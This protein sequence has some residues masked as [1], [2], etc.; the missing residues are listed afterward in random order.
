MGKKRLFGLMGFVAL[1][2]ACKSDGGG[3]SNTPSDGGTAS[4]T[5]VATSGEG[6]PA[7]WTLDDGGTALTV[8]VTRVDESGEADGGFTMR[9]AC[10][11]KNATFDYRNCAVTSVSPT[12]GIGQGPQAGGEFFLLEISGVAL[13]AHPKESTVETGGRN[14]HDLHVGLIRGECGDFSGSYN[15]IH[16]GPPGKL[17]GVFSRVN[18]VGSADGG[19]STI[20]HWDYGFVVNGA[21]STNR[22]DD[23]IAA[24]LVT[25]REVQHPVT[26]PSSSCS[27]GTVTMSF[28]GQGFDGGI[29]KVR[30]NMTSAGAI[31]LDKPRGR[32]GLIG[33]KS[34]AL[35]TLG[36]LQ[37][38]TYV[39]LNYKDDEGAQ[40]SNVSIDGDGGLRVNAATNTTLP[41]G[42]VWIGRFVPISDGTVQ[43]TFSGTDF[44]DLFNPVSGQAT[45]AGMIYAFGIPGPDGGRNQATT[46]SQLAGFFA[47]VHADGRLGDGRV[48]DDGGVGNGRFIL[49]LA[50]KKD[51]NI[52]LVG[53][54]VSVNND[55]SGLSDGGYTRC[56]AA[57]GVGP[58]NNRQ[59]Y[60]IDSPFIGYSK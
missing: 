37:G 7:V 14:R 47:T 23:P 54:H 31:L 16:V 9:A 44:V 58:R 26:I 6:D 46:P 38:K 56:F 32:G 2:M 48:V 33:L 19:F 21:P 55:L 59:L 45:D 4:L 18:V 17:A 20:D 39:V 8:V 22:S 11:G 12:V 24:L 28:P 36:D 41:D 1:A 10:S 25:P 5:Y 42:G 43:S 50:Q 53:A 35:A 27:G 30:A 49:M 13:V 40:L 51:S 29:G 15:A 57:D 34:T 60:C 3:A 52:F